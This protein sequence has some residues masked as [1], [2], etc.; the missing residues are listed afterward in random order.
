[1][2]HQAKRLRERLTKMQAGQFAFFM[3][4]QKAIPEMRKGIEELQSSLA[5]K[6]ESLPQA[7]KAVDDARKA[8]DKLD[9]QLRALEDAAELDRLAIARLGAGVGL[10]LE[11]SELQKDRVHESA[12]LAILQQYFELAA[13]GSVSFWVELFGLVDV[14]VFEEAAEKLKKDYPAQYDRLKD[15][16][17]KAGGG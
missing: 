11:E 9:N 14:P 17:E 15:A 13:V 1:M 8:A 7:R 2:R 6:D 4:N 3:V 5:L 16:F 12:Q 10:L